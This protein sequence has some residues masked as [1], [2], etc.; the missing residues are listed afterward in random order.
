MCNMTGLQ[1]P[2]WWVTLPNEW[3][4]SLS[5]VTL[6]E[7]CCY[8][9]SGTWQCAVHM[10]HKRI[11]CLKFNKWYKHLQPLQVNRIKF[12]THAT[13]NSWEVSY[14]NQCE[15]SNKLLLPSMLDW[16]QW[17]WVWWGQ[18]NFNL[19]RNVHW[20]ACTHFKGSMSIINKGAVWN[21]AQQESSMHQL[22]HCS[23]NNLYIFYIRSYAM[24]YPY[25]YTIDYGSTKRKDNGRLTSYSIFQLHQ[26][27]AKGCHLHA[28]VLCTILGHPLLGQLPKHFAWSG[29]RLQDLGHVE[30]P[31]SQIFPSPSQCLPVPC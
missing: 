19:K 6:R 25:H 15:G 9:K 10:I 18:R 20:S 21:S 29:H 8:W 16:L 26:K 3:T 12:W 4:L 23:L 11:V 13:A 1:G 24:K 17:C 27:P 31:V 5:K 30:R 2:L 7:C 22:T 14:M 28:P